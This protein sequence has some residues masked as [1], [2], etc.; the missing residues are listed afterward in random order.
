MGFATIGFGLVYL[1]VRYNSFFVLTNNI[2]TKGRAYA[3]ALQQLMT[4]VYLAEVCLIGLFAINTAPGPIILMSVFLAGTAMYHLT[5]R[6][7]LKP[8]MMYLPPSMDGED[9]VSMFLTSDHKTFDY[10]KAGVPP[11]EA[12]AATPNKF[13]AQKAGLFSKLFDPRKFKSNQTV[14]TLIPNRP[15]PIYNEQ[16]AALAYM[17]PAITS[18]APKLWIARDEM[19]ISGTEVRETGIIV[20]ISDEFARFNE[21]NKI[22][23]DSEGRLQDMPV[24]EKR[25]DY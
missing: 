5:M 20:P 16:E 1:A 18:E 12:A 6:H 15:M 9:Q 4:G 7:A 11:S 10:S 25:I 22:V 19:G 3:R 8:L 17:D 14:R 2:D 23:W 24:W 13:T 21:K